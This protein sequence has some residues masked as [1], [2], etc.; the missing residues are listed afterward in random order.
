MYSLVQIVLS[1]APQE[2]VQVAGRSDEED[3]QVLL[4]SR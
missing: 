2:V 1:S 3:G 4:T